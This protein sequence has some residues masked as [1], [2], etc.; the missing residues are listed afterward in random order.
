MVASNFVRLATG[1]KMPLIGLGT[2]HSTADELKRAVLAA[3]DIGYRHIDTAKVYFNEKAIGEALQIA[4]QSGKVKRSE[5]FITTKLH[6]QYLHKEDVLPQLREQLK[7]LQLDYVDLY[8][9]HAPGGVQKSDN[10]HP[11]P[12]VDGK[13]IADVVDHMETWREMEEAHKLGLAKHIGISNYGATQIQHLYDHASVKPH[14]L[15]CQL[16]AYLPQHELYQLCNRLSITMIS[17]GTIGGGPR[18][19]TSEFKWDVPPPVLSQD[20]TV[21]KIAERYNKSPAQILLRWVTQRGICVIPK[22]TNEKRL[23]ENF[24]ILDFTL[25]DRDFETLSNLPTRQRLYNVDIFSN[26]PQMP[27]ENE[28]W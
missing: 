10:G 13:V 19:E 8:L 5:M 16:H 22:S 18:P 20:P 1:A 28:P 11:F 27:K 21:V 3:I 23:K 26:H 9:I 24:D 17:Y 2:L 4:F 14:C 7:A 15:Q 6:V 12:M 25:N